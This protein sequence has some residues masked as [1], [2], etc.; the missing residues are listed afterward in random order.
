ME[1]L[2]ELLAKLGC[3]DVATYI[4]SGNVVFRYKGNAAEASEPKFC[5]SG[6]FGSP[7]EVRI[8]RVCVSS[9]PNLG[10]CI[11]LSMVK[12]RRLHR[13]LVP[14]VLVV[15]LLDTLTISYSIE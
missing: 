4:Q 13:L 1:V 9:I 2:R 14:V 12:A 5:M 15:V 7:R 11:L 3:E 8:K 10:V 6:L